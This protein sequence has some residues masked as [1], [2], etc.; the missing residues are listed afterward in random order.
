MN[1]SQLKKD[2]RDTIRVNTSVKERLAEMGFSI[3]DIFDR[4][5]DE[6][7]DCEVKAINPRDKLDTTI[8]IKK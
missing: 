1:P 8:K 3:Q 7:L 2:R 6:M 5:I 4:A